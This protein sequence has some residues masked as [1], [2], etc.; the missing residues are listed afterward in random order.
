MCGY[1]FLEKRKGLISLSVWPRVCAESQ[2]QGC[3][4]C[5]FH[6]EPLASTVVTGGDL[7]D[8]HV[9]G[10]P[11]NLGNISSVRWRI[12]ALLSMVISA[13]S[14]KMSLGRWECLV[15]IIWSFSLPHIQDPQ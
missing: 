3:S 2:R 7:L 6:A 8:F 11:H 14:L 5:L 9:K 13:S 10:M 1:V 15:Q 12:E 4:V